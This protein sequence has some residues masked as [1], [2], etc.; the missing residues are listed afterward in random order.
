MC[1]IYQ[2]ECFYNQNLAFYIHSLAQTTRETDVE[3]SSHPLSEI[4]IKL[5]QIFEQLSTSIWEQFCVL[6]GRLAKRPPARW[7]PRTIPDLPQTLFPPTRRSWESHYGV[8][9]LRRLSPALGTEEAAVAPPSLVAL[10]A[11]QGAAPIS[12][13]L[14]LLTQG[15]K[16]Q[17]PA[18][19]MLRRALGYLEHHWTG[20]A[21]FTVWSF[22]A[23][24]Q[25]PET[26]LKKKKKKTIKFLSIC[27]WDLTVYLGWNLAT[28]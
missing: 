16:P 17:R 28:G 26:L 2:T 22:P 12:V 7:K 24:P 8:E 3:S 9:Q 20:K 18:D 10:R 13:G 14:L 27:Y 6:A 5:P 25:M 21:H 15:C 23:Q 1:C 4:I 11:E 19:T